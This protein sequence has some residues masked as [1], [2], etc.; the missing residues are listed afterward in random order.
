[1]AAKAA[2]RAPN[3]KGGY[4][5]PEPLPAGEILTNISKGHVINLLFAIMWKS[6]RSIPL[7]AY[8]CKQN[9]Y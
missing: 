6:R 5:M 1:M 3:K 7:W 8:W 9:G 4:L 2:K